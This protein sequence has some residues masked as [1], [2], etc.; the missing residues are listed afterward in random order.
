MTDI[1]TLGIKADTTDI[2]RGADRLDD[3]AGSADKAETKTKQLR[4]GVNS[5][6]KA[7]VAFGAVAAA[8]MGAVTIAAGETAMEI[9]NLARVSG[10]SKYGASVTGGRFL[11]G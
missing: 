9:T 11:C 2:D 3:F 8:A 1:F 5:A 4:E 7:V 10:L 6:G